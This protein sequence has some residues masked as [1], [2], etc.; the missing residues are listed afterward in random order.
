MPGATNR[1]KCPDCSTG[2]PFTFGSGKCSR[3]FGSGTNVSLNS[4]DEKC[5]GCGGTGMC[6]TCGGS[7]SRPNPLWLGGAGR[8]NLALSAGSALLLLGYCGFA[9]RHDVSIATAATDTFHTRF[10]TA[11][12]DQIYFESDVV[13]RDAIG[14]NTE[15]S[16]F[17]RIRR[18]I[19]TCSYRGPLGSRTNFNVNSA[20]AVVGLTYQAKC[21]N[22]PMRESFTWRISSGRAQLVAYKAASNVLLAD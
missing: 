19:G 20:D 4:T 10:A 7:G 22:G 17:S 11:Q 15:R 6:P 5:T 18:K 21:T 13:W 8:R 3:C 12:D 16:L 2:N 9:Q 1:T 14:L